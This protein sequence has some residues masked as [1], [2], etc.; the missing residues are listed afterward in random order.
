MKQAKLLS[1]CSTP[2]F[3]SG[4]DIVQHMAVN[5]S[6]AKIAA[7][8]AIG[9]ALVIQSHEVKNRGVQ[10]VNMNPVFHLPARGLPFRSTW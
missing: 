2:D 1:H 8:V 4:Q 10:I 5:I 9:Q 3:K 7:A 6:Q